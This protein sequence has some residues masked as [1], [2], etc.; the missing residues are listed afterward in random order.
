MILSLIACVLASAPGTVKISFRKF[1]SCSHTAERR[2]FF[3]SC[4]LKSS[5]T[6]KRAFVKARASASPDDEERSEIELSDSKPTAITVSKIIKLRVTTSAPP[7]LRAFL[8]TLGFMGEPDRMRVDEM[9]ILRIY[10]V[11][12]AQRSMSGGREL[13]L[14]ANLAEGFELSENFMQFNRIL[15]V[16]HRQ[17]ADCLLVTA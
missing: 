10:R 7:R 14:P 4:S 13:N 12:T 6:A 16:S 17:F 3:G 5:Q 11:A 8:E 15:R 2:I 1:G 9:R